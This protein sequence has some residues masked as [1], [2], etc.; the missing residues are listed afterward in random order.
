MRRTLLAA[1]DRVAGLTTD[2]L[3]RERFDFVCV[4]LLAVHQAGHMF[5]D[6][7]HLDV[8][9]R[10]RARLEGTLPLLYEETDRAVGRIL[11][12]LPDDADLL[13]VSPLG[14]GPNTSR[15][16]LLGE[17]LELVL[18]SPRARSRDTRAEAGDRIWRLRGAVPTAVRSGVARVLGGRLARELTAKLSTSGI[19]WEQTK[20]FLLPSDENGQIR[21][22]L[23]GRERDG[24]VDPAEADALMEQIAAGLRTFRD[25][26]GG[27]SIE[28]VDRAADLFPGRRSDLLPDLVVRWPDV[29][30]TAIRGV[31]SDRYGEVRRRRRGG[32][33]RNGAH[34]AQ[35]FALVVPATSRARTPNRP[36]RV[37]DVA[38]TF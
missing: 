2:V 16:D 30:A 26:D 32:T 3:R 20:A 18:G 14:M 21:L 38:A 11:D 34:T 37:T 9:D 15:I 28:A 10:H 8:D 6:V 33:G 36:P 1:S 17:M 29:P 24:V 25:L 13:I 4:S 7:S 35:A 12:A 22:N 19:D 5:W 27:P 31:H 23:R